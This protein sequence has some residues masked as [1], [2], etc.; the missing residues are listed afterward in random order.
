MCRVIV[1]LL[2]VLGL[3]VP[4]AAQVREP[5]SSREAIH[6]SFAPVVKKAAPA[7]VNVYSRRTIRTQS[8][9]LED[10]F[11]RRFFGE[12]SPFGGARERVQNS[13]GS[14]VIVDP[15]GLI[16]T[17][18]HVIKD[19]DEIHVV[20][21]D[22]REFEAKIVLLDE[23]SDLAVLKIDAHGAP[24]PTIEIGDSDALEVGDLVLAIGDPFGV[25]QTVTSG[26]VSALARAIGASDF[27]SFIQTDAPINPGNSG[28]ALVD[29]DGKLVGINS[30]IYS[31]SGGSM[32]LGFAIPTAMV[33]MVLEAAKNGGKI[34]R[35]WLGASG[36]LVT[37]EI[38]DD[39]KL[40]RPEG[41]LL[42]EV[43]P[44]SPAAKAG[45]RAG[46]VVLAIDGHEIDDTDVF[47]FRIATLPLD[48]PAALDFWRNGSTHTVSVAIR[49]LP[50]EP[51][52]SPELLDG[53]NPLSGATVGNLNPAYDDELGL[54]PTQRGVVVSEVAMG[55]RAQRLGLEPGDILA[56]LNRRPIDAVS[57]LEGMLGTSVSPWTIAVRRKGKLLTVTVQ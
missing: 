33:R 47:K 41:V 13:L 7:V 2:L 23:H 28:G 32:G 12:D 8:P 45:L 21:H 31:R 27:R 39:L 9:L 19:A 11:F 52:R 18:Q 49:R 1:M 3:I 10:P 54:E 20:L 5:P 14:G 17:N 6:L 35:P 56:S 38:A 15:Q 44:D 53:A 48:R 24:L 55:S 22:R 51:P 16:V 42:K 26:I 4:A 29:L 25:G 30:E 37:Q 36:Q 40:A 43:V 34:S 57:Q 46:D 50:E